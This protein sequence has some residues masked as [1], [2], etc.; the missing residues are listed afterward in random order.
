VK[1]LIYVSCCMRM[2]SEYKSNK[3]I[4]N[5]ISSTASGDVIAQHLE[6]VVQLLSVVAAV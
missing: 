5:F 1:L 2:F 6:D 3:F 4:I